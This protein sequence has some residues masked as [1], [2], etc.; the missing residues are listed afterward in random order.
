MTV[1]NE[2]VRMQK[3]AAVVYFKVV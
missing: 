1:H 2:F 3:K